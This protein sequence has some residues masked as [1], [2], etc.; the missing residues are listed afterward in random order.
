M[1]EEEGTRS[2]RRYN[3]EEYDGGGGGG[4]GVFV[5]AWEVREITQPGCRSPKKRT[6]RGVFVCGALPG[7]RRTPSAPYPR[8]PRV[9]P[10]APRPPHTATLMI[11]PA[12]LAPS[13][14]ELRQR[15]AHSRLNKQHGVSSPTSIKR[16]VR[17]QS[18]QRGKRG[19]GYAV[20]P[21]LL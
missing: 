15:G 7:W 16:R 19:C 5:C 12:L 6:G 21:P 18:E 11:H 20:L 8:R 14:S 1:D 9:R 4:G 17:M 10:A 2:M 3:E 13:T